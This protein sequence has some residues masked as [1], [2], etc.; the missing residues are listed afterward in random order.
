MPHLAVSGYAVVYLCPSY[1][2][3]TIIPIYTSVVILILFS[4]GLHCGRHV[5]EDVENLGLSSFTRAV[6]LNTLPKKRAQYSVL[7]RRH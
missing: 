6:E 4:R 5:V 7:R 3:V 2:V 1:F